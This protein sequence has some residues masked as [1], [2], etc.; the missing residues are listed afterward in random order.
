MLHYLSMKKMVGDVT[1]NQVTDDKGLIQKSSKEN[2]V[3]C[4]TLSSADVY[5]CMDL[6]RRKRLS[7]DTW[8][9]KRKRLRPCQTRFAVT[10]KR[11]SGTIIH[12][13]LLATLYLCR[14]LTRL[15]RPERRPL[16]SGSSL[17]SPMSNLDILNF[18]LYYYIRRAKRSKWPHVFCIQV[19]TNILNAM[20]KENE[21]EKSIPVILKLIFTHEWQCGEQR[22]CSWK[23]LRVYTYSNPISWNER[24]KK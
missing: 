7:I 24:E 2:G 11:P 1:K 21:N 10:I 9:I 13:M 23:G 20:Q 16:M 17:T 8:N 15:L 14:L 6:S 5:I 3:C 19:Y 22:K 18:R 12:A 4:E